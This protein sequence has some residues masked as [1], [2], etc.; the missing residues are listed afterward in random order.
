MYHVQHNFN[1]GHEGH[2]N[3]SS[4]YLN[5]TKNCQQ[6]LS[7]THILHILLNRYSTKELCKLSSAEGKATSEAKPSIS[8]GSLNIHY[9]IRL[10]DDLG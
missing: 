3:F 2:R 10:Q 8:A 5:A 9:T 6:R 1:L 7:T 4:V